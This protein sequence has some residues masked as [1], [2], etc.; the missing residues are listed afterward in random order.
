MTVSNSADGSKVAEGITPLSLRLP[1]GQ[2]SIAASSNEYC[3]FQSWDDGSQTR[4]ISL[5]KH[6]EVPA[7]YV[8]LVADELGSCIFANCQGY[9]HEVAYAMI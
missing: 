6:T 3:D 1:H 5:L 7:R 2:H 9:R 4:R 8:N